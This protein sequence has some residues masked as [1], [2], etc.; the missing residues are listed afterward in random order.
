MASAPLQSAMS[1]FSTFLPQHSAM[2]KHQKPL[3]RAP[4]AP[5]AIPTTQLPSKPKN[6]LTDSAGTF[7]ASLGTSPPVNTASNLCE[8]YNPLLLSNASHLHPPKGMPCSFET[9]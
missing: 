7:G 6:T 3:P 2:E 8:V 4:S 1:L 5:I 9:F